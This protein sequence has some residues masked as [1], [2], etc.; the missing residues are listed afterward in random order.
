MD[1]KET[2]DL[3]KARQYQQ[4]YRKGH[5]PFILLGKKHSAAYILGFNEGRQDYEALNGFLNHGIPLRIVTFT[6]LENFQLAGML[7]LP[8][9]TEGYTESQI[10]VLAEWYK[11]GTEQYDPN[12]SLALS[13]LLEENGIVLFD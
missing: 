9:D 3:V 5:N 8:V 12:P 1:N 2:I 13:E 6:T 11:A 10:N 7:G 4:G